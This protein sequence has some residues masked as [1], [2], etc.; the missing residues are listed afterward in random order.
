MDPKTN[1][2]NNLRVLNDY[3][4]QT[5]DALARAPRAAAPYGFPG[6]FN[7]ASAF[8][9]MPG[10]VSADGVH[11]GGQPWQFSGVAGP[12]GHLSPMVNGQYAFGVPGQLGAAPSWPAYAMG[13]DPSLAQRGFGGPQQGG[14]APQH[15]G[16]G[17]P[18]QIGW[19]P[20]ET[21]RQMQISQAMAAKQLVLEAMCRAV[22]VSI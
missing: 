13:F 9:A 8:S 19:T 10:G 6:A 5:I 20:L 21:A 4:N 16:F 2:I 15:Y 14:F 12:F 3:L 17:G 22:G 7:G 11:G 18:Q 1:E